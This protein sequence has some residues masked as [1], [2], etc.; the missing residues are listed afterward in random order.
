[1]LPDFKKVKSE[2]S[3]S[4][5]ADLSSNL[6][7]DPVL[8][9][10]RRYRQHEGDRFTIFREDG[11]HTTSDQRLVRSELITFE[12]KD[13]QARGEKA[14]YES[15]AKARSEIAI[16]GRR[17]VSERL[18]EEPVPKVDAAGRPFTAELY[19]EVLEAMELQFDRNGT[20]KEPDFWQEV[21]NPRMK[22]RIDQ[23]MER[24]NREPDLKQK[25]DSLLDRKRQDFN[26]REA[27]R[28]LVD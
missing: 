3:K 20:W 26:D 4:R 17:M 15:I 12:A 14:I 1:V 16:Q 6:F 23:E 5:A 13:I 10:I 21:P 22:L 24:F 27:N 19:L 8:S 9:K 2:L 28:K 25:L 18:E 11:S 7:G